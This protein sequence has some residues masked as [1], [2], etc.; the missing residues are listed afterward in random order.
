M[1]EWLKFSLQLNVDD[2]TTRSKLLNLLQ[3]FV[4]EVWYSFRD[5]DHLLPRKMQLLDRQGNILDDACKDDGMHSM[6]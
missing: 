6:E 4:S 5:Y 3:G 2:V 1:S